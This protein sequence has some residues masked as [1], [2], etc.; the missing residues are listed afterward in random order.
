MK[1][2]GNIYNVGMGCFNRAAIVTGPGIVVGDG[3]EIPDPEQ[4][5]AQWENLTSLK[6]AKEYWNATEQIGDV[7]QAFAK[8]L[9]EADDAVQVKIQDLKSE[10]RNQK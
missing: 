9:E 7:L 1:S 8:P 10:I 6:G 5:L 3:R 4:L 2:G